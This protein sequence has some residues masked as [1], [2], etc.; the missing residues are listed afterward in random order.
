MKTLN[1]SKGPAVRALRAQSDKKEYTR[2]MRN[3]IE[4]T[5][6]IWVKQTCITDIKVKD[7]EI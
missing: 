5:D 6:N 4:S 3:I 2:Y 1:S 7:G